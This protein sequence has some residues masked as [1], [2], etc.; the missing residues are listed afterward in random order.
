MDE[1]WDDVIDPVGYPWDDLVIDPVGYPW[2]N[3]S[4]GQRWVLIRSV[5][6]AWDSMGTAWQKHGKRWNRGQEYSAPRALPSCAGLYNAL[7]TTI[8]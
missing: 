5:G 2:D 7:R 8:L 4:V 6:T 3:L 1:G